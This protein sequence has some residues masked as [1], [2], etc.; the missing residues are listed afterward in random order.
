MNNLFVNSIKKIVYLIKNKIMKFVWTK[1]CSKVLYLTKNELKL[2][3]IYL[4]KILSK[5]EKTE[6]S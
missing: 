5:R 6:F 2:V 4:I 3:I 1:S